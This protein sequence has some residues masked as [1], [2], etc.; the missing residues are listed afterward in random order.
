MPNKKELELE[1]QA[2]LLDMAGKIDI[3]YQ[4]LTAATIA[5]STASIQIHN[6]CN[7]HIPDDTAFTASFLVL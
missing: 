3:I 5:A 7:F 4:L 2:V 6:E 1:R